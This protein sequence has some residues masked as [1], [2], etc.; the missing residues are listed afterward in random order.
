MAMLLMNEPITTNQDTGEDSAPPAILV[1]DDSSTAR[2]FVGK[3]LREHMNHDLFFAENGRAALAVI[4]REPS[5]Q[6][7]VTDMYM[8]EM[9]GLELVK[10]LRS[11]YPLIPV[12]LITAE[13]TERSAV[14][15]LQFALPVSSQKTDLN[16]SF[17]KR[18]SMCLR[19]PKPIAAGKLSWNPSKNLTASLSLRMIQPSYLCWL[20]TSRNR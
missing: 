17:Q 15:A 6:L 4:E 7:V 10:Q 13:G 3:I 9:D 19:S 18:S 14:R 11:D 5:I 8:P 2:K 20:L 16:W 12:I 1:V